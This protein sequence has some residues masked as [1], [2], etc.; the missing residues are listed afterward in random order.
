MFT[1]LVLIVVILFVLVIY[2][3]HT[4]RFKYQHESYFEI[5]HPVEMLVVKINNENSTKIINQLQK[6]LANLQKGIDSYM[7]AFKNDECAE[8]QAFNQLDKEN[9]VE[10]NNG[11]FIPIVKVPFVYSTQSNK[12]V[13]QENSFH[14]IDCFEQSIDCMDHLNNEVTLYG[15]D[16]I[17]NEIEGCIF[18]R[19]HKLLT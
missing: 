16:E 18:K 7:V 11:L 4:N 5:N 14:E 10:R 3:I 8:I 19:C 6:T 12:C 13:E 17:V 1:V 2:G 9:A 15:K